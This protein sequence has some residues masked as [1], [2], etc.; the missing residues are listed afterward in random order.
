MVHGNTQ[1][2]A[3]ATNNAAFANRLR[4][5]SQTNANGR[6]NSI[7]GRTRTAAPVIAAARASHA[8]GAT[9]EGRGVRSDV[10]R[11]RGELNSD[12]V[13]AA[14][15]ASVEKSVSLQTYDGI[16]ING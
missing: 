6:K 14:A 4:L 15:S 9:G 16:Q 2:A 11:V 1:T 10:R 5:H 8:R 7:A 12:S 13:H 3:I